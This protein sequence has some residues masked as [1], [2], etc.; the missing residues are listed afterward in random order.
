MVKVVIWSLFI[1]PWISL[2]FLKGN[3]I[4]RY[5]PVALFA[6]VLNTI[7]AQMAW[8]FNWWKFKETLFTWDRLAPLFTV[9]SVFLVGTIW[10]FYFTFR[11]FWIYIIVNLIIDLFYGMGLTK[12]LNKL[13]IRENG[14]F[15][16]L[17]NLLAMTILAVI[18]YLYQIWQERIFEKDSFK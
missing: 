11:R 4:R 13:E 12:M 9:Y 16:P 6:T 18:L 15:S 14:S 5:M 3:A 7:L 1:I 10:I 2:F 8:S 17:Q